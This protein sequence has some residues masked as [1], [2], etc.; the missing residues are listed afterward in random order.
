MYC[1]CAFRNFYNHN[2][3]KRQRHPRGAFLQVFD[4]TND[5]NLLWYYKKRVYQAKLQ[6]TAENGAT[7]MVALI[8]RSSTNPLNTSSATIADSD[9]STPWKI[10]SSFALN[11]S[12]IDPH[13]DEP[14]GEYHFPYYSS[15]F[16]NTLQ[17]LHLETKIDPF[18]TACKCGNFDNIF[19]L[20]SEICLNLYATEDIPKLLYFIPGED[21]NLQLID[22]LNVQHFGFYLLHIVSADLL[23]PINNL[24][25]LSLIQDS[26]SATPAMWHELITDIYD[27]IKLL[28]RYFSTD[29]FSL[30]GPYPS[31]PESDNSG[32]IYL[33]CFNYPND[34]LLENLN[35]TSLSLCRE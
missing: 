34:N 30:Q 1:R 8:P 9:E 23:V 21:F 33:L 22:N 6:A 17:L 2:L 7:N 13:T 12:T 19:R 25:V 32:P 4:G 3:I 15:Y 5:E 10:P 31:S 27:F 35:T 26:L 18:S 20:P 24:K 16:H 28:Q 14:I 29:L 11:F